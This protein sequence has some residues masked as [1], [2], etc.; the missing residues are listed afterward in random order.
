MIMT[1]KLLPENKTKT[2]SPA[3]LKILIDTHMYIQLELIISGKLKV[4]VG[5]VL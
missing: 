3:T 1:T 2:I 4:L 5:K